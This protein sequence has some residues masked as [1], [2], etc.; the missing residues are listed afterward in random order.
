MARVSE[1]VKESVKESGRAMSER[2]S[3]EINT[4]RRK[5][6][7]GQHGCPLVLKFGSPC[8]LRVGAMAAAAS[9]LL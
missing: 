1:S 9:S 6:Q 8:R 5:E 3:V 2:T 4:H 7:L